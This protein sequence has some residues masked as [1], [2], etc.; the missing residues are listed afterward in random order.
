M[1]EGGIVELEQAASFCPQIVCKSYV[2]C[3]LQ[4]RCFFFEHLLFISDAVTSL[5]KKTFKSSIPDSR[6][7]TLWLPLFVGGEAKKGGVPLY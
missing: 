6:S 4:L 7:L 3:L 1:K 5:E 2:K